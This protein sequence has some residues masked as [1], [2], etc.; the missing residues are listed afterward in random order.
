MGG[1]RFKVAGGYSLAEVAR[2]LALRPRQVRT[3]VQAGFLTPR[4]DERGEARFSFQDLVVLR[5]AKDLAAHLPARRLKRAL[6]KLKAQLPLGRPL[7]TVRITAVGGRLFVQDGDAAWEP[8]SGQAVLSF[9][10]QEIISRAAPLARRAAAAARD[11]EEELAAEDWYALACELEAVT[12]P[13]ARD[14]YRRALELDPAH[15][16]AHINLGRLLHEVRELT[17]AVVHYEMALALRPKDATALYNLGVAKE[18]LGEPAQAL[19]AY[20]QAITADPDLSDAYYNAAQLLEKLG[21]PR[22][23][24]RYLQKYRALIA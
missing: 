5:T 1:R 14:A 8:E 22:L 15:V 9:A 18:D 16:D 20:E 21:K 19:A 2:L 10:V 23:A 17:A 24:L 11:Q 6:K 4:R 12:P 13:A 7:A 3:F